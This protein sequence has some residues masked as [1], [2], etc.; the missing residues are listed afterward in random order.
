[1]ARYVNNY[2]TSVATLARLKKQKSFASFVAK[3][4]KTIRDQIILDLDD[5]LITPVQR[6][7]RY[8]M[9][10]QVRHRLFLMSF[11]TVVVVTPL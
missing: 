11:P 6:I 9:L 2:H 10:L 1:M 4:R 5:L 8:V 3:C 7:P